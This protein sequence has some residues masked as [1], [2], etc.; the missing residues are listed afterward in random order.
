MRGGNKKAS[1]RKEAKTLP[2]RLAG[3]LLAY[4]T[5]AGAAAASAPAH[6]EVV[7]T[8]VH[9]YINGDFYLDLNHDGILDFRIHSYYIFGDG[10]LQ[11]IPVIPINKIAAVRQFCSIPN[12]G[13]AAPLPKGATI[14]PPMPFGAHAT[15]M[16]RL[17]S[18]DALFG[19]WLGQQD[20]YLG[21][22]FYIH[23]EEHYGWARMS[24]TSTF[25]YG[26]ARILGYA[27]ETIPGKPIVAGDEGSS[28][29]V[30]TVPATLGA[31]A[32]GAAGLYTWRDHEN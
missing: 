16:A 1:M 23:G 26:V 18:S 24:V 28:T 8:P 31:L 6:A 11:V 21:L 17:E 30:S 15:C 13:A 29:E 7:Y 12:Y 5:L 20:R 9:N 22:A 2:P 3:R 25:Y 27:Y 32:A 4:V 19:P 10:D 14:G